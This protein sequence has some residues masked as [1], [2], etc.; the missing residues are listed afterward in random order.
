MPLKKTISILTPVYNEEQTVRRCYEVVKQVMEKDLNGRYEYEH[1]FGDNCSTDGTLAILREL[2]ATDHRVKVLAYS[3]NFGAEKSA[4]TI[5]KYTSGDAAIGITADL[6]EPPELI[7][8]LVELWEAGYEVP[9]GVYENRQEGLFRVF[10]RIYYWLVDKLSDEPLPHNFGGYAL[11]D[12]KVIDEVL[13]TDDFAPYLRG[14]VATVGFRQIG[15]PYERP[16]RKAGRSKHGLWFLLRFG[17]NGIISYSVVPIRLTTLS[18]IFLSCLSVLLALGYAI[19]KMVNWNFQA[20][21]ATTTVVLLL[22]FSGVQLLFLGVL[23]EYIGAIHS[24]V[25]R[26]PFVIVRERINLPE[27]SHTMPRPP[28]PG[29]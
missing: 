20:P 15:I 22:F 24:Q 2:A 23:G 5:L 29:V 26:K 3:R 19:M 1:L 28:E 12:R 18:G 27:A 13:Q 14:I 7:P 6:Q 9:Y 25:R 10:R 17:L 8:K 11:L 4:F 16:A 21:G